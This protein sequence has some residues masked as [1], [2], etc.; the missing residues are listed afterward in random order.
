MDLGIVSKYQN[1]PKFTQ[2]NSEWEK[3]D[4]FA[5]NFIYL[6]H[7]NKKHSKLALNIN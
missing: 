5:W 6:K 7:V 3:N 4:G 2:I 1:P